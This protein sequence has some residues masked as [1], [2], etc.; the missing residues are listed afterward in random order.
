M[1]HQ[2]FVGLFFKF[3]NCRIERT[4]KND[5]TINHLPLTKSQNFN[6]NINYLFPKKNTV[7]ISRLKVGLFSKIWHILSS[8]IIRCFLQ[9]F[10][11]SLNN[12]R[13]ETKYRLIG[14]KSAGLE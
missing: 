14:D 3:T 6:R 5:Q 13:Y 9:V 12:N 2:M 1:K 8:F 11:T 10:Y 4:L 7:Y